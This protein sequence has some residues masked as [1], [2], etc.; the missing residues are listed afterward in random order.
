MLE[1]KLL[2]QQ[3]DEIAAVLAKRNFVLDKAYFQ[4]LESERKQLQS[5][6]ESLQAMRNQQSKKIGIMKAKGQDIKPILA[7][8]DTLGI[9]LKENEQQLAVLQKKLLDFQLTI[10]NVLHES[11]PV[12]KSEHDNVLVRTWGE[13]TSFDFTPKDHVSLGEDNGLVDF[14]AAVKLSGSRF[15]ILHH[16]LARLQRALGNFMLD[17]HTQQHAY[18]EAYVP[19]LVREDCLFGTGQLPKMRD[20]QFTLAGDSGL[21]LIPTAE[22]SLANIYREQII[23]AAQLPI[24]RVS[25][26]PCFRSEAGSYG[27]DTRGMIRQHQFQKVELVQIVSPEQSFEALEQLT[28]HAEK[29][30]QLLQ[31]PYRVMLLCSGDTGFCATKT[32]DLE[33][34]LPGQQCYREISSC[35]NCLDFQA[36]RMQTRYRHPVT[37]KPE[38]VHTLNGSG[39][40][41]G[42]TLVAIMENYQDKAGNII[43][44]DVLRPYM[45]EELIPTGQ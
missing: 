8:V 13:P 45:Q 27:K 18:H 6:T 2:R 7:E 12:G 20:D 4:Q 34:W 43:V 21:T 40:A 32:Y 25:Q 9:Q 37:G 42:R 16:K 24:R 22:V 38:F 39:L 28:Q 3:V 14:E 26:T 44:P 31:L 15:V 36:R 19:Y 29:I 23:D 10:P 11:V 17:V 35:S 41:V 1:P 30:L 33:V 5:K